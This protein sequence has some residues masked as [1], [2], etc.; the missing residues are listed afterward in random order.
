M[1]LPVRIPA[2]MY[3]LGDPCYVV[4]DHLWMGLLESCDYFQT[5]PV[6]TLPDG[7]KVVAFGTAYGDGE[8][9]DQFGSSYSVDSGLI[10]LVPLHVFK[11]ADE[12]LGKIVHFDREVEAFCANGVL[13]FGNFWID[14]RGSEDDESGE[15]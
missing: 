7:T 6:G 8:Y 5:N 9:P 1:F 2:G 10:G 3:F 4:P 11:E 15:W 14:T 13:Y 12:T